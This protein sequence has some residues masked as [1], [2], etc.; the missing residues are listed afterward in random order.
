MKETNIHKVAPSKSRVRSSHVS[1]IY[2]H[3]EVQIA[4]QY[5]VL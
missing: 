5:H 1:Y 2:I 4:T 3:E